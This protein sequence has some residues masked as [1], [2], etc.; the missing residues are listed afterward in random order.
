MP[1]EG[2]YADAGVDRRKEHAMAWNKKTSILGLLGDDKATELAVRKEADTIFTATFIGM[3]IDR[4]RQ[5]Y[6]VDMEPDMDE[7]DEAA[8]TRKDR[9][10]MLKH[11]D[12]CAKV[13]H[14]V[15][16]YRP[17]LEDERGIHWG[18][19]PEFS[20]GGLISGGEDA[21]K[22]Y[23]SYDRRFMETAW[24]YLT[25]DKDGQ[26]PSVYIGRGAYCGLVVADDSIVTAMSTLRTVLFANLRQEYPIDVGDRWLPP[27]E[28]GVF[29]GR[30]T[31][32]TTKQP[33]VAAGFTWGMIGTQ[34]LQQ[35][36]LK[37]G[38]KFASREIPPDQRLRVFRTCPSSASKGARSRR[39]AQ[40]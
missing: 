12:V 38:M 19:T 30:L 35:E 40:P 31:D 13:N 21:L 37:Q 24:N 2:R 9:E 23:A 16:S 32:P 33:I 11:N 10:A 17:L 14:I 28:S 5:G 26:T 25:Q 15:R 22:G 29:T 20:R 6:C 18:L 36:L 4:G 3:V 27:K 34:A 7:K 1:C 39:K 8:R